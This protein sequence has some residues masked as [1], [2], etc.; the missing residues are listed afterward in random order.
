MCRLGVKSVGYMQNT[1]EGTCS[2]L[3]KAVRHLVSHVSSELNSQTNF[4]QKHVQAPFLEIFRHQYKC[5]TM[6]HLNFTLKQVLG[7]ELSAIAS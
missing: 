5:F 7:L 6:M 3:Y 4:G 2:E 1:G